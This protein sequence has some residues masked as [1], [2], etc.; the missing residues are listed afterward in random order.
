MSRGFGSKCWASSRPDSVPGLVYFTA[1]GEDV[2]VE[3]LGT[4]AY[5]N[6]RPMARDSVFRIASI[7]SR[8][9]PPPR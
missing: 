7:A 3:A 6:D 5:G 8:S 2:A 9:R 4:V 1:N